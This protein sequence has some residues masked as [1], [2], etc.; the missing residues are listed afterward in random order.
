MTEATIAAVPQQTQKSGAAIRLRGVTKQFGGATAVGGVDL[1]IR[2]GEFLSLLGPS[3]CGKTTLLRMIAGFEEPDGGDIV[4]DGSSIVGLPPNKRPVNTVF[5]SYA[6]F[7]HMTV[8][9]N[10]AYGL[11]Q[12]RTPRA[13]IGRRVGEAL[14]LARMESFADRNPKNLSGGQQQ[15]VALARALVNRP[16]VLLLDE[17]MSALDRKLR[18]EMQV[19]LKLIQLQ[20]GITFVFVTH[21][22][23]EALSMSDRVVVMRE[24]AI[25]QL[26]TPAEIYRSPAN[27]FVAGFIGKQNFLR[28]LVSGAD[29]LTGPDFTIRPDR[30]AMDGHREGAPVVAV[31]RAESVAVGPASGETPVNAIDGTLANI[32]FLGETVQYVV[33]TDS[34]SELLA[35]MPAG[36]ARELDLHT[37][38]RCSWDGDSVHVFP[39]DPD[40][41]AA[42]G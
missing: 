20:L 22:Q 1:E 29:T 41:T 13:E 4:L 25:Q 28:C 36:R 7:P 37:A 33:T 24:G 12:Q 23:E 21:D 9:E 10:V 27:S 26:G 30:T 32:S 39:A 8:A 17:P 16:K 5:Q 11:R 31:V 34:G 40:T 15:R 6:L 35:R 14:R 19:E 42:A 2:A 38:V 18:E 3:G